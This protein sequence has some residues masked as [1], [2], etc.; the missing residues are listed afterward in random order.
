MNR[1]RRLFRPETNR[2]SAAFAPAPSSC[3]PFVALPFPVGS[4]QQRIYALAAYAAQ[5]Q[6]TRRRRLRA[7]QATSA[8]NN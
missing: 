2:L 4:Q 1:I 8:L 6:V 5:E 7:A 3:G